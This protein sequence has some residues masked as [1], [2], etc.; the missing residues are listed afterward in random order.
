MTS[1]FPETITD[2]IGWLRDT[3]NRAPLPECPIE[4]ATVGKEP[5]QPAYI[6]GWKDGEPIVK[7]INWKQFQTNMPQDSMLGVWFRDRKTGIG[8]LAGW[9]GEHWLG[10]IDFDV[11]D[12]ASQ[13]ACDRAVAEWM[14]QYQ[15]VKGCPRFR[16]PGGG[17]RFLIAWEKEP[18]NF[19]A[20]NGFSLSPD[21]STRSG[22]LL[23]KNGGHTL[24]PPTIGVNGKPYYWEY[25]QEYPPLASSPEAVG[26]YPLVTQTSKPEE[27]HYKQNGGKAKQ[28]TETDL[29]QFLKQEVYPRLTPEQ[30]Y[31]WP[32]HSW[33]ERRNSKLQ[34]CCPW[35]DSQ[36]GT[37]FYVDEVDGIWL[38]RCPACNIGGDPV[39]YRD[40]LNSG[41][42][43]PTGKAFTEIVEELARKAGL[44]LLHEAQSKTKIS[45][46]NP[47]KKERV[48]KRYSANEFLSLKPPVTNPLLPGFSPPSGAIIFG[49][50]PGVGKTTF[51]IDT[52]ACVLLNEKFLEEFPT[53]SG[54]VLIVSSDEDVSTLREK[55]ILRGY[56]SAENWSI[57]S[58]W[59]DSAFEELEEEMTA[60][61]PAVVIIDNFNEISSDPKFD[62]N[63]P[64]ASKLVKKIDRLM[65]DFG[66]ICL[67]I[68]H[69]NKNK[70]R[71]GIH[72][73]RGNTGIVG[74]ASACWL[75][76]ETSSEQRILEVA[77][78]RGGQKSRH[79]LQYDPATGQSSLVLSQGERNSRDLSDRLLKFFQGKPD[80]WLEIS[81][82]KANF[83]LENENT[84]YVS[85]KRL[86][87]R[88]LLVMQPSESN[89]RKIVYSLSNSGNKNLEHIQHKGS[90]N[91]TNEFDNN[92]TTLKADTLQAVSSKALEQFPKQFDINLTSDMNNLTNDL[93]NLTTSP[94]KLMSN[95]LVKL[96]E[97]LQKNGSDFL[98]NN[99]TTRGGDIDR[100]STC[101]SNIAPGLEPHCAHCSSQDE[102]DEW[103]D[104]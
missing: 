84:I 72:R 63:H 61:N 74:S 51:A 10:W 36:S 53:R 42:G 85:L 2:T 38:W 58:G 4:S 9:N 17:Y 8:T 52:A 56:A 14:E 82:I 104:V 32:G 50:D 68:H 69:L 77:K 43:H 75:L 47:G 100:C 12:F 15:I 45:A 13:E 27:S 3:L 18:E 98:T 7:S 30:I 19:G 71:S 70:E 49:G 90:S 93:N 66:A 59:N 16:T 39:A 87:D 41:D 95:N 64:R 67:L 23:T 48:S 94:V 31:N 96:P 89:N 5:K 57:L 24:L 35:H 46:K 99:L 101:G 86:K 103:I 26:I 20:N 60:V 91:L 73:F 6:S 79:L 55:M 81:A 62:E 76:L 97:P 29:T 40:R 78:C 102:G 33:Q 92:L 25:W 34:G 65:H 80:C 22:E 88:G 37:A 54:K 44:S 83:P 11:K 21:G 28:K 1:P